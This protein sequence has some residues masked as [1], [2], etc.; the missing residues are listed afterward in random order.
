MMMNKTFDTNQMSDLQIVDILSLGLP[1]ADDQRSVLAEFE[2]LVEM[3]SAELLQLT[4]SR[5]E[6]C[7]L[8]LE[9][10]AQLMGVSELTA[11]R[12]FE[13]SESL[14][15]SAVPRLAGL[16]LLLSM[17][18]GGAD[19]AEAA[20]LVSAAVSALRD[21]STEGAS[22]MLEGSAGILA[23]AFGVAGVMAAALHSVL[24]TECMEADSE[25]H[26]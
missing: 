1:S 3:P 18:E 5:L 4:R 25:R 20:G 14:A 15:G 12:W 13:T 21:K 17:G 24:M 16:C 2:N 11:R 10:A 7:G 8:G 19:E 23:S 22:G 9:G 26:F 6:E